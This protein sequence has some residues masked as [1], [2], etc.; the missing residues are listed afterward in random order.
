MY[1]TCVSM[2]ALSKPSRRFRDN[3]HSVAAIKT[4]ISQGLLHLSMTQAE[5]SHPCAGEDAILR[6]KTFGQIPSFL[7]MSLLVLA[8]LSGLWARSAW[9]DPGMSA[10]SACCDGADA[11]L[12]RACAQ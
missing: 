3:H 8:R 1:L 2:L 7:I 9:L 11:V 12:C 6:V 4:S 10:S 5:V